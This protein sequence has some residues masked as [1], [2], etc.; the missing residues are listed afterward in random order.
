MFGMGEEINRLMLI[1]MWGLTAVFWSVTFM[2]VDGLYMFFVMWARILHYFDIARILT[3]TVFK[4]I[5][6]A[7]DTQ[8]DYMIE[9]GLAMND[10]AVYGV[11]MEQR[12]S[13]TDWYM[14]SFGLTV[15]FSLFGDLLGIAKNVDAKEVTDSLEEAISTEPAE[16]EIEEDDEF[17]DAF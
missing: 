12:L 11:S 15:S 2:Q 16:E 8:E 5:G 4:V 7:T 1:V 6:M 14:E 17:V 13:G 9:D 10:G 3:S